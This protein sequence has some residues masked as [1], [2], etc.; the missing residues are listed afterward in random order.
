[1]IKKKK[2]REVASEGHDTEEEERVCEWR[3]WYRR[4]RREGR[5]AKEGISIR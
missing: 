5:F 2:K 1:M 3:S 4:R